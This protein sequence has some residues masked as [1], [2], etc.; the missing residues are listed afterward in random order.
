MSPDD[1]H[2]LAKDIADTELHHPVAVWRANDGD[3]FVLVGGRNRLDAIEIAVGGPVRV[4]L[5]RRRRGAGTWFEIRSETGECLDY[6]V[7]ILDPETNPHTYAIS[8]N[9]HRLHLTAEAKRDAIARLLK[10]DPSKSNRQ[11]A[12]TTKTSPTFVGKVRA[13]KEATGDVSTVDTRTDTKGRQQPSNKAPKK[14]KKAQPAKSAPIEPAIKPEPAV[15]PLATDIGPSSTGETARLARLAELEDQKQQLELKVV[16][17]ESEVEDLKVELAKAAVQT[18]P[19]GVPFRRASE[20]LRHAISHIKNCAA[21]DIE[22]DAVLCHEREALN[23]LRGLSA[24]LASV[25]IDEVTIVKQFAKEK[26]CHTK[27][28]RRAA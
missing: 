26:R 20:T 11:I 28:R 2:T 4:E 1:L 23:A 10:S 13:E 22:P 24:V 7:R 16:G 17:L 12:K 18:Y 5:C 15:E 19:G 25:G 8:D 27:R 3:P 14:S 21:P 9:L 6:R